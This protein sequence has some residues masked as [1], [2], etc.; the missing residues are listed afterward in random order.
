MIVVLAWVDKSQY[1]EN[2]CNINFD[3]DGKKVLFVVFIRVGDHQPQKMNIY[4][5][6]QIM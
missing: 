1:E 5:Y 3:K 2:A 6:I 4:W